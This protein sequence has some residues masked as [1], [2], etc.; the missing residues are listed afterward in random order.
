MC[1]CGIVDCNV[2]VG[3]DEDSRPALDCRVAMPSTTDCGLCLFI[4]A[5][6]ESCVDDK[7]GCCRIE[8]VCQTL[9]SSSIVLETS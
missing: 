6:P 8:V 2:F 7:D 9:T 5:L 4:C 1:A 3:G